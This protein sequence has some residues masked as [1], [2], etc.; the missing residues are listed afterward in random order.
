MTIPEVARF[1]KVS[2]SKIYY[3][4]QRREIPHI[5]IQR[6]VRIKQSELEKWLQKQEVKAN[7]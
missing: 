6:N 3:L 4:I 7:L 5:K 2:K 1:L